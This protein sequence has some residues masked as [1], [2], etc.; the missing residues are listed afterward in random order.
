MTRIGRLAMMVREVAGLTTSYWM[1]SP[2]GR[3]ALHVCARVGSLREGDR[4][5]KRMKR[6]AAEIAEAMGF[7][8]APSGSLVR[9][10]GKGTV[11]AEGVTEMPWSPRVEKELSRLGLAEVK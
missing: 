3:V 7:E 8:D 2:D 6:R 11:T 1:K 4:M 9:G 5:A 10:D